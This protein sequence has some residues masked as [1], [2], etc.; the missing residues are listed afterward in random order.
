MDVPSLSLSLSALQPI[1]GTDLRSLPAT[2][3]FPLKCRPAWLWPKQ[4]ITSTLL[5]LPVRTNE[6]PCAL[7]E[8]LIFMRPAH[9][10]PHWRAV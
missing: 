8:R 10:Y 4:E 1:K 3:F 6:R 2:V 9:P 7:S 5:A